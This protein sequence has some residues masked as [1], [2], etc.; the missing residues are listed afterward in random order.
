MN[1][2]RHLTISWAVRHIANWV[3][4]RLNRIV[5]AWLRPAANSTLVG[6]SLD[7]SRSKAELIAENALLRHQL[8]LLNRRNRRPQFTPGDR[9]KL[10]L[11]A[12][13]TKTCRE[14]LVG[15]RTNLR[16]VA[17]ARLQGCEAN[18]SAIYPPTVGTSCNKPVLVDLPQDARERHLGLRL[19]AG[20]QPL[21]PTALYLL[22]HRTAFQTHRSLQCHP[23]SNPT[24]SRPVSARSNS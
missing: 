6:A 5:K 1:G 11:L 15:C 17:Q 7:L 19:R 8:V 3:T 2:M 24:L 23:A 20:D 14:P 18:D 16:G 4:Q 13:L 21:V 10:L 9:F 22:H 12:K